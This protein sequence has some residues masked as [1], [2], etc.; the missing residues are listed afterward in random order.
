MDA[1]HYGLDKIKERIIEFLAVRK[2]K[3]DGPIRQPILCFYGPPGVGKTSLGRSIAN[4]MGRKFAR[5]SLGGMRDEAE[6]R[7]HRRT[8]IGALPGQI[9]Q[10][11]RR[12]E[13][14]NPLFVLD[15][16]DK[17]GSDFRGDPSSALLG[18]LG[19]GAEQHVQGPLP[20]RAVRPQPRVLHH[21][22][23]P[24]G[25]DSGAVAG[26]HG[27]HRARRVH[28]GGEGGD[29][30]AAPHPQADRGA[31]PAARADRLWSREAV[32]K[33]VRQYTREAGVRNLEREVGSVCRK[34]T[35]MVADGHTRK[36]TVNT[37]VRRDGA[38]LAALPA[39]RGGGARDGAGRS[40]W[41]SPGRRS[42]ATCC[43][44]RRRRW[45]ATRA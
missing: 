41:A 35:R 36:I 4:A 25:H 22:G 17:L 15:E 1:D 42:A 18:G 7:G 40:R 12:A 14:S 32:Q 33:L 16:I 20:G 19:P 23:E 10:N 31:W 45:Q 28:G 37:E 43:S 8:Y 11:L 34:A 3:G 27:D 30:G 24:S 44:S 38:G 2:V 6:I 13:S 5:I 39:R 26:P 21:H 9:I 29:R